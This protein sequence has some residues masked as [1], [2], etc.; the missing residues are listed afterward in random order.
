LSLAHLIPAQVVD[1]PFDSARSRKVSVVKCNK[2]PVIGEV[3]VGLEKGVSEINS[4]LKCGKS[5]FGRFAHAAPMGECKH[6]LPVKKR[7]W[8]CWPTWRH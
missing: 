8:S 4:V 2:N 3:N 5:I 6:T 1:F 7:V